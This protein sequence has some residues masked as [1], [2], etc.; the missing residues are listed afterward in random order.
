MDEIIVSICC[1]TYN[2]EN[3]IKQTIESFLMQ[4]VNFKYE[5]I[6][7]DDASTD[8]TPFIIKEYQLKYPHLIKP[9]YQTENQYSKGVSVLSLVMQKS[10]G[11]YIAICEGDD[12]WIDP[13]KLQKQVEYLQS[14]Y[15]C[16]LVTHAAI[17][18][19]RN[20][21]KLKRKIQPY[22][23]SRVC[24]IRDIIMGDGG[25][26]STNSMVFKSELGKALP[27]FYYNSP[28][29]DYPLTI[30][31]SLKGNVYYINEEMSAY[32]VISKGSW[33][34]KNLFNKERAVQHLVKINKM[35]DE[36]NE[37]SNGAVYRLL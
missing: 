14:N 15:D 17:M 34:A 35:L 36:A 18:V 8:N 2:Q 32:R 28:V 4:E 3:Y 33:S 11:K 22:S 6:I 23:E 31:L 29:R 30:F 19:D 9:I 10:V 27:T 13:L 5:I 37:Y 21:H 1:I 20:G 26:F 7:H 25:F 24:D 12:F 16:T